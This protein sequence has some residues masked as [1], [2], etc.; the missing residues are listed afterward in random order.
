MAGLGLLH[1]IQRQRADGVHA[2]LIDVIER[3]WHAHAPSEV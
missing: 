1:G 3:S 2:E